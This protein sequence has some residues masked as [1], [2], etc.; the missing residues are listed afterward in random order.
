MKE[1]LWNIGA[2]NTSSENLVF[3]DA[4]VSYCQNDWLKKVDGMFK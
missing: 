1:Q 3:V 2:K 4:D